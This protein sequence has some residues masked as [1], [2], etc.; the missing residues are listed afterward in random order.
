MQILPF[1]KYEFVQSFSDFYVNQQQK[2]FPIISG[3]NFLHS[4]VYKLSDGVYS[5]SS[6]NFQIEI[7]DNFEELVF[8]INSKEI[9][10][11]IYEKDNSWYYMYNGDQIPC[12][13]LG[14]GFY[15]AKIGSYFTDWFS[16]LSDYSNLTKIKVKSIYNTKEIPYS[17]GFQQTLY[18]ENRILEPELIKN[19]VSEIDSIGKESVSSI[20]YRNIYKINLYNLPNNI[21]RFIEH[22]DSCTDITVIYLSKEIKV[23]KNQFKSKSTRDKTDIGT[24]NSE[25]SFVEDFTEK[26][27]FCE[28]TSIKLVSEIKI[29]PI[30]DCFEYNPI[31]S[32]EVDCEVQENYHA[33]V[34]VLY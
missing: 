13:D 1:N 15:Y 32:I 31:D 11:K 14:C 27:N 20:I 4:F 23:M 3:T 12:L 19:T 21:Y 8:R 10:H 24:F 17:L 9:I 2:G 29:M 16:V 7:Y 28:N 30:V 25:I 33:T 26:V 5:E 34:L 22:L 6:S 18:L